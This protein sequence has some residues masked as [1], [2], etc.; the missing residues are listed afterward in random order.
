M[1]GWMFVSPGAAR[2]QEE[3]TPP[4]AAPHAG[5]QITFLPPPMAGTLSVGIYDKSGRLV[6]TFAREATE[7]DF[8]VGL[9]GL[10]THWDGK[11]DAGKTL[12]AATYSVRGFRVGA[13]SVEGVAYHCNDWMFGDE[14]PRLRRILSLEL[15]PGGPLLLTAEGADGQQKTVESENAGEFNGE[16]PPAEPVAGSAPIARAVIADGKVLIVDRDKRTALNLPELTRPIAASLAARSIWVIDELASGTEVKEYTL[17]GEFRR[18]LTI[19]PQEPAPRAVFASRTSELIFLIEEKPGIQRVRGLALEQSAAGADGAATSTWKTVLSK[20][21]VASD[22]FHLVADKLGRILPFIPKDK[23]TVRL[24][25]NSLL[26]NAPSSVNVTVGF[27]QSGT[28]LKTL[29]GLPL[30]RIAATPHL[31]WAVIGQEGKNRELTIFQ[32][33]GAV[34]DEFKARGL[35]KMMAFDAGEYEWAPPK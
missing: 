25:P 14:S 4:P 34:V 21:I 35:S 11:D 30:R 8:T 29:D 13:F 12:P 6:R 16:I 19:E 5:V 15:R 3:V 20:R 23:F 7:K 24:L 28:F 32:G 18:R 26:K 17:T 2:A 9:N 27:D 1:L 33:D 22:E 10:I 31:R